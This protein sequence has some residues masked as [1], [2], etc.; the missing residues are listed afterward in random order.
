M[1]VGDA[2]RLTG[3]GAAAG[4]VSSAVLDM[5]GSVELWQVH[6][7]KRGGFL[8]RVPADVCVCDRDQMERWK[9]GYVLGRFL[10]VESSDRRGV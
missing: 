5:D 2:T 3:L 4:R 10:L 7:S 6:W 8:F 9:G 1:S